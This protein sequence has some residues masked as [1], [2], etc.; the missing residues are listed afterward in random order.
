MNVAKHSGAT[1]ARI[2]LEYGASS[3]RLHVC[4]NGAG[5]QTTPSQPVAAPGPWG[6]FGLQGMRERLEALGGT[7][8]IASDGG[9][10]VI[11]TVP[12]REG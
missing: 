6:G 3:V 4:D 2:L 7:L 5:F 8:E 9:A 1:Q 10:Q 11:A 12:R